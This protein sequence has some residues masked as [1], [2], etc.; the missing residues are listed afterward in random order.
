VVPADVVAGTFGANLLGGGANAVLAAFQ[1]IVVAVLL[2]LWKNNVLSLWRLVPLV[3]LLLAPLLVNQA[4]IAVL[5]LPLAFLVLFRRDFIVRPGKFLVAA[6][7]VAG[8]FA[9]MMTA[10]LMTNPSGRLNTWGELVQW[11]VDRQTASISERGEDY[12]ALSRWTALTFWAG[13]HATANPVHTLVGH[14]LGASREQDSADD[15]ASTLA[16][17]RYAGLGIGYTAVSA[18]LWDTG[19]VGLLTV[20]GMFGSAFLMAGW[21]AN[22]HRDRD[23]RRCSLFE[24][25]QAGIAVLT[26]GLAHKDFF[27]VHIPYQTLSYLLIGYVA[28]AWLQV[29][30]SQGRARV[31]WRL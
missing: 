20:L 4:K 24:G 19:L 22:H 31:R 30:R 21:L 17:R 13:E 7:G 6:A 10:L 15:F 28:N 18:L 14:G 25:L 26:L 12:N 1:V 23:P 29:K 9:L 11:V 27:V 16:E 8:V 2:A 5:Y 3:L